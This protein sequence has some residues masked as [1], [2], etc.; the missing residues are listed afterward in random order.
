[1]KRKLSLFLCSAFMLGACAFG[2]AA[3]DNGEQT[4]NEPHE[5]TYS[6]EWV[7]N[8]TDHWHACTVAGCNEATD[9][10]AHTWD[11][12]TI[13]TEPTCTEKG[14]KTYTCTV[15]KTTKT[16]EIATTDH[17]FSD[18]WE[19]D[20]TYHWH[21]CINC[22][23]IS[24]KAEHSYNADGVCVC[25]HIKPNTDPMPEFNP[26]DTLD[27]LYNTPKPDENDFTEEKYGANYALFY[28]NAVKEYNA[29]QD[30][31][32]AIFEGLNKYLIPNIIS[33]F[34]SQN[35]S[36]VTVN[37]WYL[38]TQNIQSDI[39]DYIDIEFVYK[40]TDDG[41]TY[42]YMSISASKNQTIDLENLANPTQ[43]YFDMAFKKALVGGAKYKTNEAFNY[44]LSVQEQ[45]KDLLA[46]ITAKIGTQLDGNVQS[47][48]RPNGGSVDTELG[49]TANRYVILNISEN[50]Y[51]EFT[52]NILDSSNGKTVIE[53]LNNG[54]YYTY[55]EKSATY[56]GQY[57]DENSGKDK[58]DL[59]A[60]ELIATVA[61]N[62]RYAAN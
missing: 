48:I 47:Y 6:A 14:E 20:E 34:T 8:E 49:G 54:D 53:N 41:R 62:R 1:M 33:N 17:T 57:L 37:K 50:G 44:D 43:E 3:C 52:V 16:E 61:E 4:G 19:S 21:K 9:K 11:N 12:G 38:K 18:K 39:V 51:E 13:T 55:S 5:H 28:E 26:I 10:A 7:Y 29:A 15:C 25:G 59:P 31:Q 30:M 58:I 22:D 24:G 42:Y 40:R 36:D 35:P 2:F 23:E 32:K 45:Y 60:E 46:A 56:S 27:E